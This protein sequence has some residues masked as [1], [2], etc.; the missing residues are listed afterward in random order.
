[1]AHVKSGD[2]HHWEPI[3]ISERAARQLDKIS[4]D[5]NKKY[6][7]NS[8]I[9]CVNQELAKQSTSEILQLQKLGDKDYGGER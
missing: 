4:S 9:R 2:G 3:R 7:I 8:I 1:V 6:L 5:G